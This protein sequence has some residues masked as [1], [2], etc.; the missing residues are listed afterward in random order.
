M[1]RKRILSLLLA[2][3]FVLLAFAPSAYAED[4]N[5]ELQITETK[6]AEILS[7]DEV[8]YATF[9]ANGDVKGIY[10]VNIFDVIRSGMVYDYGAY[11]SVKNLTDL[12]QINYSDDK[13]AFNA[14]AG[15]YYY[16]GNMDTKDLPWTFSISYILDGKEISPVELAGKSGKLQIK[17]STKVNDRVNR[18]F[19]DNYMLQISMAFDTNKCTDISADGAVT[20]NAGEN[21]QLTYTVMPGKDGDI[22]IT[23][24]VEN[25]EMDGI[26]IAAVPFSM[27]FD[28]PDLSAMTGGLSELSGA[29]GQL[30]EGI[31]KMK[32]G[33]AE[34]NKG[35]GRLNAGS[36]EF[37]KGLSTVGAKSS[38]LINASETINN[39]LNTIKASLNEEIGE[40]NIGELSK[41]PQ[42]LSMISAGLNEISNGLNELKTNYI[43][44]I[45]TLDNA[46][47]NISSNQ[48]SEEE[49]QRLI[50][51][52]PEN[53]TVNKLIAAYTAAL[54]AKGTYDAVKNG[55]NAVGETLKTL[56][57]NI[58]GI[59]ENINLMASELSGALSNMN[60]SESLKLLT[61]G[62][63]EL[64]NNYSAFN[65]GLSEYANGVK[66]MSDSYKG[67]ASGLSEINKGIGEIDKGAGELSD[68]SAQLYENT[69]DLPEQIDEEIGKLTSD[70][71]NSDFEPISFSSDKNAKI[72]SVQFVFKT[73]GIKAETQAIPDSD[74]AKPETFWTKFANLFG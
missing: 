66:L 59:S 19:Y 50:I 22:N 67:I 21:K 72:G 9:G 2:A 42:S 24:N 16:Q 56:S 60:I 63:T 8:V 41:L 17:I 33:L 6:D 43:M 70:I 7:K 5:S 20:A 34:L 29:V 65:K 23:M 69:K 30:N 25:F 31:H 54:K 73:E 38:E 52:N 53:E 40:L 15:K 35:V 45:S 1:K 4:V 13:A 48:I 26:D 37:N 39:A 28:M 51:S 32:D 55:L 12:S 62:I 57:G 74:E 36:E 58:S 14:S 47:N 11:S 61:D 46:M 10:V 44:L 64:C 68:G 71:S 3:A 49:L 27:S 18:A